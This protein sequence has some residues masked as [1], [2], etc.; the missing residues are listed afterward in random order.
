MMIA[1]TAPDWQTEAGSKRAFEVASVK[2]DKDVHIPPSF[3]LDAGDAFKSSGGRFLA[4]FPLVVYITFS[5]KLW[6]TPEQTESM[7]AH[8]P[9][10]VASE[11]FTIDAR[12]E[13]A[14]PT[15]DQMRMMMQ[16]LLA[17]R[18]HLQLHFET[19]TVPLLA[20]TLIKPGRT[21]PNLRPHSEGPSCDAPDT[22]AFPPVCDEHH[23]EFK[24]GHFIT[25][26]RHTTLELI[27]K[28]LPGL[29]KLGRPVVDH[30]GLTGRWDF[31][32]EWTPDPEKSDQQLPSFIEALR[33]QLG[34]KL[35]AMNGPI[36]VLVID[37]VE[38]PTEN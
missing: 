2:P 5:Y 6:L 37:H 8:L 3:S 26:S 13:L 27:A 33:E 36:R 25:G 9:K 11:R 24:D 30:T 7:L 12:T 22:K 21:G 16:S 18:F 17:E 14:N 32:I 35:E 10:W 38:R 31:K 34:V 19:Q 4:D 23:L 20:L 29:G 1:Q 28:S 15:K